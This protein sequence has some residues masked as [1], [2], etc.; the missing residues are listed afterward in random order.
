MI[1]ARIWKEKTR[2][3][4]ISFISSTK[5]SKSSR[6]SSPSLLRTKEVSVTDLKRP[7]EE[8]DDNSTAAVASMETDHSAPAANG[9]QTK[10]PACFS[11]R[12][13][14]VDKVLFQEKSDYQD[15]IVFQSVTYGKVLVLDGVIQLRERDECAYQEMITHL[16]LSSIPETKQ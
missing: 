3:E 7:R 12:G 1:I 16:P 4:K 9:E 2:G 5:S 8:E 14:K 6:G 10:E 15:V 13:T 11:S